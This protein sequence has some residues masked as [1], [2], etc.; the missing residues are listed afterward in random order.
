MKKGRKFAVVIIVSVLL[1]LGMV[2]GLISSIQG[3]D[4]AWLTAVLPILASVYPVYMGANA[5]QKNAEQKAKE[6]Q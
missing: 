5:V 1:G 6:K 3:V 4:M 2:A